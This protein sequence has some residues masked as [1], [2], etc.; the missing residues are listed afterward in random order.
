MVAA[1]AGAPAQGTPWDRCRH[2]RH[3]LHGEEEEEE[4]AAVVAGAVRRLTVSEVP[5][6][7]EEPW[8]AVEAAEAGTLP[9][10]P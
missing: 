6:A 3:R 9:S 5:A 2:R 1:G 4:E 7:E 8:V 10:A